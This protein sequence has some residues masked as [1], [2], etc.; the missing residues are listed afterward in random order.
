MSGSGQLRSK[1]ATVGANS[2]KYGTSSAPALSAPSSIPCQSAPS[3]DPARPRYHSGPGQLANG[4]L[5]VV[6]TQVW[7]SRLLLAS[8]KAGAA[9]PGQ[10]P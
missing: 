7:L 4:K 6:P 2:R 10:A 1:Y 8:A 9:P 5:V 3:A